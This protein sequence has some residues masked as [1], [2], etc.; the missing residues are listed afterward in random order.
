MYARCLSQAEN[1]T[2][3]ICAIPV[4]Q[5]FSKILEV[6]FSRDKSNRWAQM[7]A[8]HK[9]LGSPQDLVQSK[10]YEQKVTGEDARI[11][12]K[13]KRFKVGETSLF[14][15]LPE[16]LE[17]LYGTGVFSLEPVQNLL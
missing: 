14:I 9:A 8:A 16:G 10:A 17:K 7:S 12:D 15:T 3:L 6:L 2:K 5:E 11:L 4:D 1:E 13:L